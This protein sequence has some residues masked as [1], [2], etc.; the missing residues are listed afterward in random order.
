MTTVSRGLLLLA[1][2][3]GCGYRAN[4]ARHDHAPEARGEECPLGQIVCDGGCTDVAADPDNCGLCGVTCSGGR[5]CRSG[6]CGADERCP[7]SMV[8]CGGECRD[9]SG[10]PEY[11]GG[12]DHYLCRASE[13]CWN[14]VCVCRVELEPCGETGCVDARSDPNNCGG[15]GIV[16][17]AT[18]TNGVCTDSCEGEGRL[19]D[20]GGACVNIDDSP[21]HCGGCGHRCAQDQICISGAC[22]DYEPAVGCASCSGCGC[23]EDEK[24]CDLIGYGVSCVDTRQPCPQGP[25]TQH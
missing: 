25:P 21:Q 12:C 4:N 10:D 3:A 18:C 17:D 15:C 6:V 22:Y 13:S 20:C 1:A 11:C 19:T 8:D 23:P 24:C 14:G 7:P 5:A 2:L 16:C 9:L